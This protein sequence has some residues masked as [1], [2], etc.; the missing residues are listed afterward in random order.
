MWNYSIR[1]YTGFSRLQMEKETNTHNRIHIETDR[2]RQRNRTEFEWLCR[3]CIILNLFVLYTLVRFYTYID[4]QTHKPNKHYF[5]RCTYAL[6]NRMICIAECMCVCARHQFI[7]ILL[8]TDSQMHNHALT[9]TRARTH[10]PN[11]KQIELN[12]IDSKHLATITNSNGPNGWFCDVFH[13]FSMPFCLLRSTTYFFYIH[14]FG[15]H[16]PNLASALF[17]PLRCVRVY[18]GCHFP[19]FHFSPYFCFC[20]FANSLAHLLLYIYERKESDVWNLLFCNKMCCDDCETYRKIVVIVVVVPFVW[21][22]KDFHRFSSVC[23][24]FCLQQTFAPF[25]ATFQCTVSSMSLSMADS[26]ILAFC[27][28]TNT[29][30]H[31]R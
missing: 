20:S 22:E 2:E 9:H 19:F 11:G 23:L 31:I 12:T 3:I 5:H 18:F 16:H 25:F 28:H 15:Q 29:H 7:S 1:V 8:S 10:T 17:S 30:T 6:Y 27:L 14:C 13:S 4:G 24:F 21:R 26:L